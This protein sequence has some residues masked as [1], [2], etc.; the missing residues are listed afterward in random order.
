MTVSSLGTHNMGRPGIGTEIECIGITQFFNFVL[1]APLRI[2]LW[3]CNSSTWLASFTRRG[4]T[5]SISSRGMFI[6]F[7]RWPELNSA[8]LR[9]SITS[10]PFFKSASASWDD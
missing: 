6:A 5:I 8:E 1:A 9:T 2:P 4:S 10:A 7:G 3:Q